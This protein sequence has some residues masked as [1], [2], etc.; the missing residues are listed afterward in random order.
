MQGFYRQSIWIHMQIDDNMQVMKHRI[1]LQKRVALRK[2]NCFIGSV[3][4]LLM[5]GVITRMSFLCF[6]I[7]ILNYEL[8]MTKK[9][10]NYY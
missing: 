5:H 8:F 3:W 4:I 9:Y 2:I 10:D 6:F 7:E 1:Y